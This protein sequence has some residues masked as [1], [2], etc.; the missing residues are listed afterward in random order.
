MNAL[1]KGENMSR[2]SRVKACMCVCMCEGGVG[3]YTYVGGCECA[4]ESL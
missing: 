4:C 1:V 3:R 2:D